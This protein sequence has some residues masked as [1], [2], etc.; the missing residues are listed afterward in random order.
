MIFRR[1]GWL[2]IDNKNIHVVTEMTYEFVFKDAFMDLRKTYIQETQTKEEILL[3]PRWSF[4]NGKYSF[5]VEEEEYKAIST[6]ENVIYNVFIVYHSDGSGI[7]RVKSVP[8]LKKESMFKELHL[9]YGQ[10]SYVIKTTLAFKN[11]TISKDEEKIIMTANKVPSIYKSILSM[12]DYNVHV[13]D[14]L[15]LPFVV[16]VAIFKG[17][18]LLMRH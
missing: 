15:D 16:W 1:G 17:V 8:L 13:H 5:F 11:I 14:T 4:P 12:Y 7:A 9:V 18:A 3:Y 2:Y 6:K 10:N